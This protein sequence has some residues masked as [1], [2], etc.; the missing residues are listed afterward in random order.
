M[1]IIFLGPPGAGKGTQAK[2]LV[3]KYGIPQISTG[4]M[5][6]EHVAKGT[7]LGMKA[8]EYMEKGQL[9]PDE[10]ILSMVKERLSQ[11]DAQ[12]GFILDGFPRTVAQAEALDKLLEEM[13][14][15]IE[16][17]LALIVP[18]E[19]LVTRL[20]G[21]R[22]CK[23]CGMM[24]HIKFKPPKVEGKCDACGGELYQRADDNEET[25][26][27]RLKV[28]HEQTAPLIEYYKKKGVLFEV[29]GNK[30]I[31]EITQQLINILEKK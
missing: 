3:E 30:S 19:E 28:Y 17:V 4:D 25:V 1:N 24:Y 14:K 12:K 9:V 7:E 6:R 22:T 27:N 29:D 26:R 23:N 10:I 16:Y 5:L 2:I 18:D 20:T 8:K 31:E 21:R 15:K 11:D 13:G